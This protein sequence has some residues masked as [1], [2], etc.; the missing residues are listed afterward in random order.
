MTDT[1]KDEIAELRAHIDQQRARID[2][3]EARDKPPAPSVPDD[4]QP[5]NPIDRMSM[6]P[7][8]MREMANAVPDHVVRDIALR[9]GRAPTG[10][11]SGGA[12]PSSQ[13]VSHVRGVPG[14]GSGYS[15]PRPLRPPDGIAMIDAIVIADDVR[16]RAERKR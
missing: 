13:P 16:Q 2:Q 8:V 10:P 3:L 7:S 12:I 11:S 5:I 15:E 14:G 4:W 9:D 1:K 6:P